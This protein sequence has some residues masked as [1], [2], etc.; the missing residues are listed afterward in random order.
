MVRSPKQ[1]FWKNRRVFITGHSGFKGSWMTSLILNLGAKVKGLSLPL[2]DS[3]FLFNKI[4]KKA[5]LEKIRWFDFGISTENDGK[6]LNNNLF[7]FKNGFG[8]G[9]TL[10]QTYKIKK[11]N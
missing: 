4:I 7:N 8:G 10:Y 2:D 3:N 9:G 5:Y 6:Y 1:E 11:T